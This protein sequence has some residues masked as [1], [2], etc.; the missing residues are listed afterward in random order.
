MSK[1]SEMLEAVK[2]KVT[3]IPGDGD[4]LVQCRSDI[5]GLPVTSVEI[6]NDASMLPYALQCIAAKHDRAIMKRLTDLCGEELIDRLLDQR[7][8]D[9]TFRCPS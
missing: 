1:F 2:G 6:I 4:V 3:L 7:Q 8:Q 9:K 5:F